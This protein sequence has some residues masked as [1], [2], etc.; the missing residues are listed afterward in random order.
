MPEY[1]QANTDGRLHDAREYSVSPLNRG[2]LYGDAVYEVWR[3]YQGTLFAYLEHWE[4]LLRSAAALHLE[5]PFDEEELFRQIERTA[6]AFLD[7]A[8]SAMPLYVRLQL[9]RGAGSIGLDPGLADE[10][11]FTILVRHLRELPQEVPERGLHLVLAGE[12]RRNHP[13]TLNP[14]WKTGNYLNNLLCLREARSRGAD[15]VIMVNLEN[16]LTEASTQ[17]IFFI[18]GSNVY[19]PAL[20]DGILAGITRQYLIEMLSGHGTFKVHETA[21]Y[22]KQLNEFSEC[23]LTCTTRDIIPVRSIENTAYSVGPETRTREIRESFRRFIQEH[24][25]SHPEW[26]LDKKKPD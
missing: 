18:S 10:P 26:R 7:K 2:F 21:L 13:L 12:L 4:R 20:T 1:I 6:E 25:K 3:T 16:A 15:E 23:F 24:V 11:S 5:V 8:G 14:L 17:N 22:P 9:T 19:T